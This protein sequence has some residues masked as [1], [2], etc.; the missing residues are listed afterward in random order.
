[1]YLFTKAI[2][3]AAFTSQP[4]RALIEIQTETAT[5]PAACLV[6]EDKRNDS[7]PGSQ[8][9]CI[10]ISAAY[11]RREISQDHRIYTIAEFRRIL[12]KF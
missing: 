6:M 5:V 11:R 4:D 12:Q 1:M 3:P 7:C 2:E 8:V 9:S 10:P